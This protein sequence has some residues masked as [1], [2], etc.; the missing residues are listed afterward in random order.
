MELPGS[1]IPWLRAAGAVGAVGALV[2]GGAVTTAGAIDDPG[3]A[4]PAKVQFMATDA[5]GTWFSCDVD[6]D[7]EGGPAGDGA[8][9]TITNLRAEA[10]ADDGV[11]YGV[12]VSAIGTPPDGG[13]T[14]PVPVPGGGV[15]VGVGVGIGRTAETAEAGEPP[16]VVVAGQAVE[17]GAVP[18]PAG[19]PRPS[20][21]GAVAIGEAPALPAPSEVRQGT[22]EECSDIDVTVGPAAAAPPLGAPAGAGVEAGGQDQEG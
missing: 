10:A 21:A 1:R 18:A 9:L 4:E 15:G 2:I 17:P 3:G 5:E 6:V 7:L 20:G 16:R 11:S 22:A 12:V 8:A 19:W 14:E 13:A